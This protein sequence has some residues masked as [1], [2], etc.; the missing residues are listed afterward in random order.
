MPGLCAVAVILWIVD[1]GS[2]HADDRPLIWNPIKNS[3]SSYS[4]RIGTRLPISIPVKAGIEMG[5]DASKTGVLLNT[6][7][8]FWGD[9]T[10]SAIDQPAVASFRDVGLVMNALTGS[11]AVTMSDTQRRIVTD[12]LDLE[13][14]R[15]YSLRYD[16]AVQAWKG[17]DFS[18]S[19]RLSRQDS[20]TALIMKAASQNSFDG[21][22]SGLAIEQQLGTRLTISGTVD[23]GYDMHITSG[24]RANYTFHW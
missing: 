10:L 5:M 18:Q 6:P 16:G 9:L 3:D 12:A 20:G 7:V 17:L 22:S 15:S 2:A 21:F 11:S 23:Q 8:K 19:L 1:A 14:K 4:A 13:Y 24:V